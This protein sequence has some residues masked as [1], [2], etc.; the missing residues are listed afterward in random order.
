[1]KY[2]ALLAAFA[3]AAMAQSLSDIPACAQ[4]C[5]ASAV[6]SST[7][8]S[9]TDYKCICDNQSTVVGAATTC[10]IGACGLT[11][12]VGECNPPVLGHGLRDKCAD[13]VSSR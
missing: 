9:A 11:A 10:V 1:M 4:P 8:C 13:V 7:S 12:A 2:I 3:S 5:I 6:A